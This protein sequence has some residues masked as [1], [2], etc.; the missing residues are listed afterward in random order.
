MKVKV[1]EAGI[2]DKEGAKLLLVSLAG[3]FPR[4]TKV[5]ADSAYRGLTTWLKETLGWDLEVV[6]LSE[7]DGNIHAATGSDLCERAIHEMGE[8]N[9]GVYG[10]L[11]RGINEEVQW[12]LQL[13]KE[14]T[15]GALSTS[16][17]A[18]YSTYETFCN[19]SRHIKG[20][21]SWDPC[22]HGLIQVKQTAWLSQ[23]T[24]PPLGLEAPT[25]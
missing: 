8:S 21:E 12:T 10:L 13:R 17:V 19:N 16:G 24:G 14:T 9:S 1:H 22:N 18:K 11:M 15:R 25:A 6:K 20:K 4:M 7:K 23:F 5:W 3:R 2:H